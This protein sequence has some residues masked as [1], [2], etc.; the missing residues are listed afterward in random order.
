LAIVRDQEKSTG[1]KEDVKYG[2]VWKRNE[3]QEEHVNEDHVPEIILMG[4]AVVRYHDES[5]G[6]EEE[7][8]IPKEDD[9][10]SAD[11]EEYYSA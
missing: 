8:R 2:K 6:K 11:K 10:E 4:F 9:D 7:V 3:K 1:K 5:I